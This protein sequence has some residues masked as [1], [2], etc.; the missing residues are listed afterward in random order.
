MVVVECSKYFAMNFNPLLKKNCS[1]WIVEFRRKEGVSEYDDDAVSW[2]SKLCGF[3]EGVAIG[4]MSEE[5]RLEGTPFSLPTS[6]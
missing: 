2:I 3:V 6:S 1:A 4:R 5:E